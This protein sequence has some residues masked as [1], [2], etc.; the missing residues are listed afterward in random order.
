[1]GR[2]RCMGCMEQ[3]EEEY[4]VCPYCGYEV[5][6][7]PEERIHLEPGIIL[8]GRYTIGKVLGYGGFGVTYIAWDGK[9]QQKVAVKEYMP[10]EFSTRMPGRS[11]ITVLGGDRSEQYYDGLKKF[12]EEAQNLAKFQSEDGIVTVFDSFEENGTAYIIMEYLEGETL[13]E[14]LKREGTIPE[15]EAIEMLMPVMESLQ[16]VHKEGIVH[17]DIAPDNIFLTK[18]G[19]VKLIDFGASRYATTSHSRS[20]TVIIKPGYSPEEQYRSRG[21]QGPH[22]DVYALA[23]TLYKMITGTTPPDA[24]ERRAKFE[25]EGKELLKAPN[26][27]NKSIS[28]VHNTAILNALNIRI[29]DRTPDIP[30]FLAELNSPVPIVRKHGKI[31]KINLYLWPLWLKILVPGLLGVFVL[32][33]V[34]LLT[35]VINLSRYSTEV[36]IPEGTTI[37]PEVEELTKEEAETELADARLAASVTGNITSAYI[38]AGTVVLQDPVA[39]T[40]L[41]VNG[42]VRL[43]VS[44]GTGVQEAVDGTA[45]VPYL[46]GNT[47]N[48]AIE[49]LK[50]AG[51][52]DPTFAE[53]VFD[54]SVEKGLVCI[55]SIEA[56]TEVE[57]GEVLTLTLSKGPAPVVMP[58]VLGKTEKDAT[59]LLQG[60][61]YK[62]KVKVE[63]R[64]V[65]DQKSVGKVIAQQPKEGASVQKGDEAVIYIGV[66]KSTAKVPDV[67][68]KTEQEAKKLL[69][70][71]GFTVGTVNRNASDPNYK[72]GQVCV[73]K[74]EGETE[75]ARGSAVDLYIVKAAVVVTP[76]PEYTVSFDAGS[77][78]TSSE[79]SR[80]VQHGKTIGTLP[81]IT[82]KDPSTWTF[83]GWTGGSA[84]TVVTGNITLTAQYK[85]IVTPVPTYTVTFNAGSYGTSSET[86]RRVQYGKTIG[87]LPSVTVKDKTAWVFTG[88]SGGSS[89]T[90][91]TGNITLTAQYRATMIT[92]WVES[93]PAGAIA[94]ADTKTQYRYCDK[95]TTT[96][97]SSTLSGWTLESGPKIVYGEWSSWG[98]DAVSETDTLHVDHRTVYR[99]YY[100]KCS[101]CGYHMPYYDEGSGGH[102]CYSCGKQKTPSN[103]QKTTWIT[104]PY[105][106]LSYSSARAS[107][108]KKVTY[109]GELW[110]FNSSDVNV[111]NPSNSNYVKYQYRTCTKSTVYTFYRWGEWKWSDSAVSESS[112]RQVGESRTLYRYYY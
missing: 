19:K 41:G 62:L 7:P 3:F 49:K 34:L 82:V 40:Y 5:G 60:T 12:V 97:S 74:P 57:E 84:D 103:S 112:T 2:Q 94:V 107:A 6:T 47:E 65:T 63:Q 59:D 48:E 38:P 54:E 66:L 71:A 70:A 89:G 83:T 76:V 72:A 35:G 91:V 50:K 17:R 10:G 36:V 51:L 45:V 75:A 24:M 21:D 69:E 29:E 109:N 86:S 80:R 13:S 110:Y 11:Q 87:T 39:G 9:L 18:N 20:L 30:T 53:P 67:R 8:H 26:K 15:N 77:Y 14:Y 28:P 99:L 102:P 23:A 73:Q 52:G 106:E 22:T 98:F 33:G 64:T 56:G 92:G 25:N 104:T 44:E 61:S 4:D 108:K 85:Q 79:S 58:N 111:T 46:I 27:L 43:T 90:T 42:K 101:S 68:G 81:S 32:L 31:K 88:W 105:S 16:I 100:Y 1:M 96:S 78:G 95:E 55:Q 37:V 93:A